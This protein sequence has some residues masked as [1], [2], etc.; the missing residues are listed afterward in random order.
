MRSAARR[1]GSNRAHIA[2][3]FLGEEKK[4]SAVAFLPMYA[5]R[6][7]NNHGDALW[8]SLRDSLRRSGLDAPEEVSGFASRSDGWLHR[9]LI[10]GQTCG[11]PYITMLYDAV[12]LV[13]TPDYG[14]EGCPP[15]FYHSTLVVSADDKRR[16]L[17]EFAGGVFAVNGTESQSGYAAMMREA[18]PFARD[19]RF[20]GRAIHTRSHDA[21]MRLVAKGLAD[22][23]AIDSVTWR[24]SRQFDPDKPALRSIGTTEPTPGLPFI[25]ARGKWDQRLPESV[26]AGVGALPEQTR[27]AFG[28]RDVTPLRRA[29]YEVIK[30]NLEQAEAAHSLPELEDMSAIPQP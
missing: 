10:L 24:L 20:F 7:A 29:D 15:G 5:V 13:G 3:N 28:L 17:S 11:L 14:V 30:T 4:M 21:S 2:R 9:D 27:R 6:G 26:R 22:I 18:A 25:V 8:R 19:G 1:C 16:R 12:E 23:A